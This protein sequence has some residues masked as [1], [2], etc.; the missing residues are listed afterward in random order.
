MIKK[1]AV[2]GLFLML[3]LAFALA[4]AGVERVS[5]GKPF[6]DFL[7][8]TSLD[9][10]TLKFKIPSLTEIDYL[11]TTKNSWN[12]AINIGAG[13]VNVFIKI[14]NF[15]IWLLNTIWSLITFI[16]FIIKNGIDMKD[17]IVNDTSS[18]AQIIIY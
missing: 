8:R 17:T 12:I 5:L 3:L 9:M 6:M 16:Y 18:V 7:T 11:D 2:T 13:V 1:I 4:I 15:V 10:D 14:I